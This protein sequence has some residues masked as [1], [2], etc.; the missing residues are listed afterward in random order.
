MTDER[1]SIGVYIKPAEQL[2]LSFE[3]KD[4]ILDTDAGRTESVRIRQ[5]MDL[6][7]ERDN[8]KKALRKVIRNGGSPGVDGMKVTKL[9]DYLKREWPKVRRQLESGDY[10]PHPVKRVSIPKP[11][12]GLRHLGIPTVLDRFIQQAVLQVLQNQWDYCTLRLF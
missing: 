10:I 5:Q 9:T 7:L 12:G 8:L 2:W 11:G 3:K 4:E 1:N 6:V